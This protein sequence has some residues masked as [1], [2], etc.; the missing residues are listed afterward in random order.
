[1]VEPDQTGRVTA[2]ADEVVG[3]VRDGKGV[4]RQEEVAQL[5]VPQSIL[6]VP[7]GHGV[8]HHHVCLAVSG[9]DLDGASGPLGRDLV[10]VVLP[11]EAE[12]LEADLG[13]VVLDAVRLEQ[14]LQRA[15]VIGVHA[16][17]CQ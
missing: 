8:G 16:P 6:L 14:C 2:G 15:G 1:V 4:T 12:Q 13:T 3:V 10:G 17:R 7:A 11:D 5:G 9:S